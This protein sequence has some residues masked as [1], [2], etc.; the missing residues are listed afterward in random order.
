MKKS[1][2]V[3]FFFVLSSLGARAME[4]AWPYEGWNTVPQAELLGAIAKVP[5]QSTLWGCGKHQCGHLFSFVGQECQLNYEQPADYP[6]SVNL[7]EAF[8]SQLP[9]MITASFPCDAQGNFRVGPTPAQMTKYINSNLPAEYQLSAKALSLAQMDSATL[10]DVVER[11]LKNNLP[12]I[13]YYVTDAQAM[14]MHFYSIV[15]IDAEKNKFL[16]LDTQGIGLRRLKEFSVTGFLANMNAQ[17]IV[18]TV[19]IIDGLGAM[20]GLRNMIK[21][22]PGCSVADY[23]AMQKWSNFSV[24]EMVEG[25]IEEEAPAADQNPHEACVLQ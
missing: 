4:Q 18:A 7:N 20:L 5:E 19:Q 22:T 10:V 13:V 24:I 9:P 21:R 6:L 3:S 15:G 16:V 2:L 12:T 8:L 11:N 17:S 25:K 14:T 23:A 1:L